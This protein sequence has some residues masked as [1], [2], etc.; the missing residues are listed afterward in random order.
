MMN[1]TSEVLHCRWH[2][3]RE[4][5]LRC[6]RCDAPI[7]YECAR[8]TSV[9]YLCPDCVKAA[10]RRFERAGIGDLLIGGG[11]ALFFGFIGALIAPHLSWF[12]I[13]LAPLYGTLSGNVIWRAVRRRY[14]ERLWWI[15]AAAFTLPALPGVVSLA[16]GGDPLALVWMLVYLGLALSSIAYLLRLR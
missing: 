5:M 4:T 7:C 2:P 6:Y 14:S 1:E 16:L 13:F 11:L 8:R 15:A 10:K 9:G 12:V 3:E